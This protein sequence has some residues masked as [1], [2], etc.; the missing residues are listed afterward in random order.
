VYRALQTLIEY[1]SGE[2]MITKCKKP[3]GGTIVILRSFFM[4][5]VIAILILGVIYLLFCIF[6]LRNQFDIRKHIGWFGAVFGAVY[7]GLYARFSSQWVYL[8]NLYNSIKKSE[9]TIENKNNESL[10]QWKAGFIEDAENLHM[11]TKSSFAPII[12]DWGK[13]KAVKKAFIAH[14]PGGKCRYLKLMH[15]VKESCEEIENRYKKS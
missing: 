12:K 15:A 10:T 9:I 8:S 11:A 13:D 14:T 6:D 7:F 3:N 2:W 1:A 4:T 5:I